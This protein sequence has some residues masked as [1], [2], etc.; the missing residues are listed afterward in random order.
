MLAA[1]LRLC[2]HVPTGP[3]GV[4]DQSRARIR[5]AISLSPGKRRSRS[6]PAAQLRASFCCSIGTL[7]PLVWPALFPAPI[8]SKGMDCSPARCAFRYGRGTNEFGQGL[9][10]SV[11]EGRVAPENER[12]DWLA[13]RREDFAFRHQSPRRWSFYAVACRPGRDRHSGDGRP[14][15]A[16]RPARHP[17]SP[18]SAGDPSSPCRRRARS[19]G[20][21]V[22]NARVSGSLAERPSAIPVTTTSQPRACALHPPGT[23]AADEGCAS[24][25]PSRPSSGT[26]RPACWPPGRRGTTPSSGVTQF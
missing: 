8:S 4:A 10:R 3:N 9:P 16:T 18:M 19:S 1:V 23:S 26:R 5:W 25:L 14:R 22:S 2:G 13:P 12:G 6:L 21:R 11:R 15:R 17:D 7:S 24:G 20:I